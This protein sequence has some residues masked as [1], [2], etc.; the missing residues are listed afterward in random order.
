MIE[1]IWI[2]FG[3]ILLGGESLDLTSFGYSELQAATAIKKKI[4]KLAK[5]LYPVVHKVVESQQDKFF[6]DYKLLYKGQLISGSVNNFDIEK[7]TKN[8]KTHNQMVFYYAYK[9]VQECTDL[10][11]KDVLEYRMN[12]VIENVKKGK[13]E[14]PICN[15]KLIK[16][17]KDTGYH[18]PNK[19]SLGKGGY[20]LKVF[21]NY[22]EDI[23]N[24]N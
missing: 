22:F 12:L 11:L 18:C 4:R 14:C 1:G 13:F 2:K 17:K 10:I 9:I 21:N 3:D 8:I 24:D 20:Y 6:V 15:K 23:D 19:H 16:N 7:V 5:I